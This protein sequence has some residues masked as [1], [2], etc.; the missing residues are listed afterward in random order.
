[1]PGGVGGEGLR[2]PSLSRFD[3]EMKEINPSKAFFIKLGSGG[4]WEA[5]C[6]QRDQTMRLGFNETDHAACMRGDWEKIRHDLLAKGRAKGKATEIAN[7]IR[8]FY[9][10]DKDK[11]G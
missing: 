10:S 1:M 7:E 6:L 2:G 9:E 3:E 11:L 5:D 4:H 8:Y